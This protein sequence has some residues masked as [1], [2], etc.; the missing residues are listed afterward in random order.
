MK[1]GKKEISARRKPLGNHTHAWK[2]MNLKE[3]WC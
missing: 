2:D 1:F 3:K